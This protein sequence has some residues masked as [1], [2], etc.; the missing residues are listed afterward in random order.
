M[1]QAEQRCLLDGCRGRPVLNCV[2][3]GTIALR[4]DLIG[5]AAV[6]G[7]RG[8]IPEAIQMLFG[9]QVNPPIDDC[10][11]RENSLAKPCPADDLPGRLDTHDRDVTGLAGEVDLPISTDRR[12][13]VVARSV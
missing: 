1:G 11:R 4:Y 12:A 10:R 5:C 13:V 7:H 9:P 6:L 8:S 3:P 2:A